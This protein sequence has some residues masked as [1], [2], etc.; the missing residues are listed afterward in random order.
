MTNR[1]ITI[2]LLFSIIANSI[3]TQTTKT[4]VSLSP[5]LTKM[6]YLL[7]S[8]NQLIGCTNYCEIAKKDH[9]SIISSA[10][11]VNIEKILLLKPDMVITTKFTKPSTIEA[12]QKIGVKVEVFS[13]PTSFIEICEQLTRIGTLTGKQAL[14]NEIVSKQNAR[15]NATKQKTDKNNKPKI[16]M[17]IGAKPLFT[18][19]PKTF[20]DDYINYSG[21]INIAADLKM[22][23]ISRESVL[24]RNPDVIIIVTMGIVANDEKSNWK[25]YK[26][27]N[28]SKLGNIF[29]IDSDKSCSPTPVDFADIVEQLVA[30]I[31]K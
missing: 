4:I 16:F 19:I 13:S 8:Q 25:A 23:I 31:Y 24:L 2:T 11:E 15:L 3:F 30:L 14:A 27:L 29:I 21:G 22:G 6:V 10:M 7:N 5:S 26:E 20:M 1:L 12:L 9:K 28:A 18:A 17:E